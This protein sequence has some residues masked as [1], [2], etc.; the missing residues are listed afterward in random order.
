MGQRAKDLAGIATLCVLI[1]NSRSRPFSQD[2]MSERL[3]A[4]TTGF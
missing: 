3:R 2:L 4:G 1:N